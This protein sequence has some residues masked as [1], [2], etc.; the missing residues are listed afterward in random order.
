MPVFEGLLGRRDD[1][2]VLDL[3]F[4]LCT[5][6]AYAKLRLHTSSTLSGL[7]ETTKA[8]GKLL[9]DFAKKVCPNHDTRDLPREEAAR[10]RRRANKA[11][12][13]KAASKS[14]PTSRVQRL[15]NLCTYKLHALGDYVAA[16][17]CFGPTDNYT[18][19]TVCI[20]LYRHYA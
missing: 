3:L 4:I 20:I 7:D 2:I 6:H 11:K 14:A 19:Q 10:T 17:W 18:T 16:I 1:Q 13:G 8:L 12:K 5:W 9:R 15:F